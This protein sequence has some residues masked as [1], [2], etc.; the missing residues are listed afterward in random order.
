MGRG[1]EK[2]SKEKDNTAVQ[3]PQRKTKHAVGYDIAT[4]IA[5][6]LPPQTIVKIHTGIKAYFEQD[7]VMY[8]YPRSSLG[9]KQDIT[10]A[11]SVAVFECDYYNNPQNEGEIIIALRNN[12]TETKTLPAGERIAQCVFQKILL[13]DTEVVP[14]QKRLGG[15]GSTGEQ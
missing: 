14:T 7:E 4:P 15:I 9:I 3:L 5:V 13:A 12:G 11:N 2:I 8:M 10:L 1:F 6:E